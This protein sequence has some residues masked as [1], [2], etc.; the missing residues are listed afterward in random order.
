MMGLCVEVKP[1]VRAVQL[2]ESATRGDCRAEVRK[3]PVFDAP[4]ATAHLEVSPRA[5]G[6]LRRSALKESPLHRNIPPRLRLLT[7]S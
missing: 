1:R 7:T 3:H 5:P 6:G 4:L 2:S